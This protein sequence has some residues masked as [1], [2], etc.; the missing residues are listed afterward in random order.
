MEFSS[1]PRSAQ[2]AIKNHMDTKATQTLL[3]ICSGLMADAQ[4]NNQEISYLR[5]WLTE[6]ESITKAWP[7][8]VIANRI[9]EI[10]ADGIVTDEERADLIKLLSE[11]SGNYFHQTGSATIEAPALPLDDDPS[12]YFKNMTYCFTGEFMYGTRTNCERAILRLGSMALDNVTKKLNY[13]VIGSRINPMWVNTTY[14][15]KIEKAV[16]YRDSGTELAIISEQ[17]WIQAIADAAR[18]S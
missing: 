5:T 17:Q 16:E 14:G 9:D 8:N 13:L 18:T 10:M 11:I 6:N 2:F 7:G 12:I 1:L 3:G 4:L 15:R